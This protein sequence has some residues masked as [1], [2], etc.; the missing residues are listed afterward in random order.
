MNI[1]IHDITE[2]GLDVEFNNDESWGEYLPP[3][4][5]VFAVLHIERSGDYI[6]V[7]GS[8]NTLV[9]LECSRCLALF[10]TQIKSEVNS[11]LVAESVLEEADSKELTGEELELKTYQ[12]E[13]FSIDEIVSENIL[14]ELPVKPLC[15]KSCKG[16]CPQCGANLNSVSC[17]CSVPDDDNPFSILKNSGNN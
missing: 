6:L 11:T 1:R 17:T 4:G 15:S 16:L 14:V 13:E 5:Q 7:T 3:H 10:D 12:G 8:A 9:H 2:Q